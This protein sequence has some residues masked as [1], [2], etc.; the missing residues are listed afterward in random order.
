SPEEIYISI[1]TYWKKYN[2]AITNLPENN[3]VNHFN[4][5]PDASDLEN[6]MMYLDSITYLPDDILVKTDR[7]AMSVSLETRV[8]FLDHR[9][10]EFAWQVPLSMKIRNNRGK[11]LVRKALDHYVPRNLI[12]RPKTGFAVP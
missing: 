8:P 12:D 10:V 4:C 2:D 3:I 11:W 5:L 9:L 1:V 7:A 6:C